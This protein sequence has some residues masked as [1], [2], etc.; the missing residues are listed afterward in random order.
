MK[1]IYILLMHTNTIPARIIKT[2]TK[3]EYSHVAFALDE[4]CD[5]I[6]SFGRKKLHSIL[7]SGFVIE[8]RNGDFFRTFNKTVC[9]IYEVQVTDIQYERVKEIIKTM[10]ENSKN[11]KYDFVGIVLRYFGIPLTFKNRYVCSYFVASVL[12]KAQIHIFNKK[13]CLVKP[14]DFSNV[15]GFNEIYRGKYLLYHPNFKVLN[16]V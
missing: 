8:H 2:V 9:S 14:K 3:Y 4:D 10:K 7:D 12:E 11:Y 13:T 16:V 15:E 5:T 1:K 6:Y